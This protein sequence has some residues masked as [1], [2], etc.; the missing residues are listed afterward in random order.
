[1]KIFP[2]TQGQSKTKP[3]NESETSWERF[4][5]LIEEEEYLLKK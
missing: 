3:S 5:Y 4:V 2:S 1:V